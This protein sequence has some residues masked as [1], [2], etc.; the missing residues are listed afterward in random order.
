[1]DG[2]EI[3]DL[4][5][6]ELREARRSIGMIFQ[7]FNLM[8][9]RT[10]AGNVELALLDS[11]LD[12]ETRAARVKELLGLVDLSDKRKATPTNFPAGKNSVWP[13]PVR[14]PTTPAFC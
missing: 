12:R 1:M 9:S 8:P 5:K 6:K 3:A 11:G 2:R 4:S 10:V 7:S 14:W 13:S